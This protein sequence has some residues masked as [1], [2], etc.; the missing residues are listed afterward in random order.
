VVAVRGLSLTCTIVLS[1]LV[2][3]LLLVWTILGDDNKEAKLLSI[4]KKGF[5]FELTS[6]AG[7]QRIERYEFDVDGNE[8]SDVAAVQKEVT[9]LQTKAKVGV[10]P[11]NLGMILTVLLWLILM[12]GTS[13]TDGI[14]SR[15]VQM[16][17]A[18][19]HAVFQNAVNTRIALF[20][21]I[22][23][24]FCEVLYA[25]T[26]MNRMKL[27]TFSKLSWSAL[28]LIIGFPVT[29]QIIYLNKYSLKHNRE[30][31]E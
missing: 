25:W 2:T 30:K 11:V 5:E 31:K 21:L 23:A 28:I 8:L 3:L 1:S 7:E 18:L 14:G 12:C 24:H 22:G 6:R 27:C 13:D 4:N 16:L 26:L 17:R 20:L 10:V 19:A 29:A 15:Y 9:S